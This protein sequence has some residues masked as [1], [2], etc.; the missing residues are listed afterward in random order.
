KQ[1]GTHNFKMGAYFAGESEDA[2]VQYH[3]IDVRDMLDRPLERIGFLRPRQFG[4][5]DTEYTIF[6]QDHWV[7]SPRLALDLCVRTE[8]QQ[9][10]G[11][12]RVAPRGGF[13]WNISP[14]T[15]T[16]LRAGFGFFYEHVPLNVY[17]FN[18]YP[19]QVI[20]TFDPSSGEVVGGPTVYL[21]T[22]GQT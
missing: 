2:Q 7:I 11:A 13:A 5:N 8:L 16:T 3:P 17:W 12:L 6:G 10:S 9:V 21:N 19:D 14:R 20:T 18:R 4:I 22:L 15:G 1:V